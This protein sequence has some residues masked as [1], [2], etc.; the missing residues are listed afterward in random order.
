EV[1]RHSDARL[2]AQRLERFLT[3]FQTQA[4]LSLGELWAWPSALKAT[5]VENLRRL[6]EEV[7]DAREGRKQAARYLAPLEAQSEKDTLPPLPHELGSTS[8]LVELLA[9][10][11]EFG[12]RV[13]AL[14]TQL[15]E[16]LLERGQTPEDVIRAGQQ[17]E[18]SAQVSIANT[19]TSLRLCASLDWTRFIEKVSLVEQVL[20]RDPAAVYGRMDFASRDRYRQAVEEIAEAEGEAQVAV[21]LQAVDRARRPTERPDGRDGHVGF[22]LIGEGRRSFEKAMAYRPAL[23]QRTRRAVF[24]HA[25]AA[26]LGALALVTLTVAALAGSWAREQGASLLVQILVA[27]LALLPASE[28]ATGIVQRVVAAFARPRRLPRFDFETGVPADARTLVVIPTLLDSVAGTRDL[29]EHLEVQAIGN[30]DPHVHFAILGDFRDA[31]TPTEED[32]EQ[33]LAAGQEAIAALNERYGPAEER[34]FH[35]FHRRR[36]WNASEGVFMGWERKRGKLEEFLRLLRGA[37]DTSYE[38]PAPEELPQL[39]EIRYLVTLDRDTRLPRDTARTLVGIAAHPLNRPHFD[40]SRR[41][42]TDGYGIL[43]PRVSVTFESAAGSLFARLYAG[44]TGVDPYTTAVSDTYQDLF[45][46]GIF[47]GKGLLDVDAFSA[48]LLGRVP[49]NALLSHDLFEG[50]YARTALV[51]D[52]ELVDDYPGSVVAHAQ[53]LHRWVRGDWQ[54]LFWL[55]PWVR[56]RAGMERNTLPLISR[57]KIFDNL[58]RSLAAPATLAFLTGAWTFFPGSP[59]R[60][61]ALAVAIM[62]LPVFLVL[63]DAL[64]G[65]GQETAKVFAGR[66]IGDLRTALA[67]FL[68]TLTFLAYRAADM[69]HAIAL[70]LVRLCITQRR[71]LEWETAAAAARKAA[72]LG[73][74]TGMRT[75]VLAMAVSPAI[76][77]A[78]SAAVAGTRPDRLATALPFLLLWAAAPGLAYLLSR[79]VPSPVEEIRESDRALFGRLCRRSWRY[80]EELAGAE[81]HGLPPDNFQETPGPMT[82]HRTSP[83]NIGLGLLATLAAHDLGYVDTDELVAR[84]DQAL[85]TMESLEKHLGH[86]LNWYDTRTL[87]PLAPRYVSTVDSGNL[88]GALVVLAQSLRA[89]VEAEAYPPRRVAGLATTMDVLGETLQSHNGTA[90]ATAL[91]RQALADWRPQAAQAQ[92]G[93]LSHRSLLREVADGLRLGADAW[94]DD[95]PEGREVA[96]WARTA[97][98]QAER[99]AEAAAPVSHD[100]LRALAERASSLAEAMDFGFLYD[101]QRKLFAIGYRLA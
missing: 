89:P 48:A 11:R 93:V 65:R 13:T 84:V 90:P 19:I 75:F 100:T 98:V 76:A 85:T 23:H 18:A 4:P 1:I 63:I 52:V 73:G 14:R 67:R 79:P 9:R 43:Q 8:L 17:A 60:W 96:F 78:A 81:D 72:G 25:T 86:L 12:P 27:A 82:A 30:L 57:F 74:L 20:Q 40:P 59:L 95:S 29:V 31:P 58:R 68:I 80:F 21:A 24:R 92:A 83:T 101:R 53:R 28:L 88:A 46:E 47:T 41:R 55:L 61:T 69:L 49:E 71:L 39:R 34:R 77:L 54:I 10:M 44:H 91:L 3:A 33:I 56:T 70:T 7:L 2:D 97:A 37:T 99:C 94:H 38:A 64:R 16:R 32:D 50:L 45:G 42:V 5:L 51:S 15:E 87:A 22:H 35:L 62:A 66:L 6:A 36:Q 26:Y